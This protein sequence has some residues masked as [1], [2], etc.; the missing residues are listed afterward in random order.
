MTTP[1]QQ[2]SHATALPM[3]VTK[4]TSS[5][6]IR[7]Y[8]PLFVASRNNI[9]IIG[10]DINAQIGKNV[11]NKF[12]LHNSSN[13]NGEHRT[14]FTLEN[15]LT[16]LNIN[17]KWNNS[18]F[19]CEAYSSFQGMSS[20][21]QIVTAKIWLSLRRNSA[22]TTTTVHYDWSLLNNRDIRDKYTLTLRNK[23]DALQEILETPTPNDKQNTY[24]Q[25]KELNPEFHGRL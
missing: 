15:R 16:C 12:R 14:D 20:D 18:A 10:G 25:N 1:A 5:P 13:R 19:N 17:E 8:P 21:H 9:L 3:L 6:S 7:S 24:Q 23:F 2:S 11:N 4:Q 22:W